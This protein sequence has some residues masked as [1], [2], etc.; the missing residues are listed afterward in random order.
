MGERI[1]LTEA[2]VF[3]A[4]RRDTPPVGRPPRVFRVEEVVAATGRNEKTVKRWLHALKAAGRLELVPITI[5]RLDGKSQ[6]TTGYRITKAAPAK[7][8]ARR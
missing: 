7:R 2:E 4:L 3:D 5:I 1:E 8:A 6:P